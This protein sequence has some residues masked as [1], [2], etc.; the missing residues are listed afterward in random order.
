VKFRSAGMP[1]SDSA[2][3]DVGPN[4]FARFDVGMLY[5]VNGREWICTR[6]NTRVGTVDL[7]PLPSWEAFKAGKAHRRK[8]DIPDEY[9]RIG[10]P[11]IQHGGPPIKE[12]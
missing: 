5:E 3:F 1:L 6:I 12:N 10:A 4:D 9:G 2:R 11:V 7:T 8:H